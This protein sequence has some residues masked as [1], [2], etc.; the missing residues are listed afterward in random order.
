MLI[1][2]NT[3]DEFN[4]YLSTSHTSPLV[5]M[6]KAKWCK[7]CCKM[8]PELDSISK[9][10]KSINFVKIDVDMFPEIV[11]AY[12]VKGMPSFFCIKNGMIVSEYAGSK[13][14][15]LNELIKKL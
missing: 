10:K 2:L 3:Q 7:H 4:S 14:D 1:V 9:S 5:L 6:F 15:K 12:G 8:E 11:S 13:L